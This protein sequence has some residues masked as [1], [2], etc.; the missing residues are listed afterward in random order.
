MILIT[1]SKSLTY[2]EMSLPSVQE[3]CCSTEEY[4]GKN[5]AVTLKINQCFLNNKKNTCS[6]LAGGDLKNK[7]MLYITNLIRF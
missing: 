1:E 7:I 2:L 3:F 5:C 6:I 4:R